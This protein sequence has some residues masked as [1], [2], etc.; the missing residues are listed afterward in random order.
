MTI[1]GTHTL[2]LAAATLSAACAL[3]ACE[4]HDGTHGAKDAPAAP[5]AD[6]V[7]ASKDTGRASRGAGRRRACSPRRPRAS[8]SS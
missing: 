1:M 2:V 3:S 4:T 6:T 7:S 5:P 8:R